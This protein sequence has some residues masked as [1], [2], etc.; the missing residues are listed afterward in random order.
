MTMRWDHQGERP[1]LPKMRQN[2]HIMMTVTAR[3]CRTPSMA[4]RL[5]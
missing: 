2:I 4:Q 3:Y 5:P 1:A